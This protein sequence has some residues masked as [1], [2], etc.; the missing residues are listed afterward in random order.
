MFSK[1]VIA[2]LSLHRYK[3]FV[4]NRPLPSFGKP[5]ASPSEPSQP[6]HIMA[7]AVSNAPLEGK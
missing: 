6:P 7:T 3:T 5:G 2:G 4:A 1:R